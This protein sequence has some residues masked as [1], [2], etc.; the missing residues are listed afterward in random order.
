MLVGIVV[1]AATAASLYA[2][3]HRPLSLSTDT[4]ELSI[5]PG[6]SPRNIADAWVRAQA[7]FETTGED[8]LIDPTLPAETLLWRLFN[9][10][11]VRLFES[12]PLTAF[13]RCS[14]DRIGALL[15]QFPAEEREEMVEA[16][17]KIR[18]TCEYCART[19]AVTP[20]EVTA[21][22]ASA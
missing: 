5:E 1:A 18:V 21:Q 6:T 11:G 13:C 8:E 12:R 10:D 14:Q 19:Y 7:L 15:S 17:G 20:E 9:E 4:V 2:W 3:L 22:A 16:D